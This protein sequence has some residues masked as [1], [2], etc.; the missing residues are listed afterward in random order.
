MNLVQIEGAE[1]VA[2]RSALF[3]RRHHDVIDAGC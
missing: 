2:Q 1:L 3:W